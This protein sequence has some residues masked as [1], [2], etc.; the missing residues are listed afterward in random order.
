MSITSRFIILSF[1]LISSSLGKSNMEV[2]PDVI[3]SLDYDYYN[4]ARGEDVQ[5]NCRSSVML[6]YG[7]GGDASS[8][9]EPNVW[10]PNIQQ[11]CC[12]KEDQ[13]R[14]PKLW[15]TTSKR[16]ATHSKL[17]LLIYKYILGFGKSFKRLSNQ[18][19]MAVEENAGTGEGKK[20]KKGD[21]VVTDED[22]YTYQVE[23]SCVKAAEGIREL[24]FD[25]SVKVRFYYHSLSERAQFMHN[26]RRGFYCMMCSVEGLRAVKTTWSIFR[27]IY[28]NRVY[29]NREFCQMLVNYTFRISYELYKTF[30]QYMR[31]VVKLTSCITKDPNAAGKDGK[32]NNNNNSNDNQ[33][34]AIDTKSP[35]FKHMMKNPLGIQSSV[36]FELCDMAETSNFLVFE[37]CEFYCQKYHVAKPMPDFDGSIIS[38][39]RLYKYL[40]SVEE[41]MPTDQNLFRADPLELKSTIK[42]LQDKVYTTNKF[43]SPISLKEYDLAKYKSDFIYGSRGVNPL[44]IGK[45]SELPF[46]YNTARLLAVVSAIFMLFA[47]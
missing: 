42:I 25:E 43:M 9:S 11:N 47:L 8:L 15:K 31:D 4:K 20:G 28:S 10:C 23:P 26:A 16:I 18:L 22:G 24:G 27:W 29:Y 2:D 6:A 1:L 40:S 34:K 7:L 44:E 32:Q 39:N 46:E 17:V 37:K 30:N 41:I 38:M 14:L 45:G 3:E 35:I 33:N 36:R 19:I 21:N 13:K 12:G 5:K